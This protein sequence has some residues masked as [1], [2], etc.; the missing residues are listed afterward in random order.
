MD[1]ENFN[2]LTSRSAEEIE[3]E[4]TEKINNLKNP[5]TNE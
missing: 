5:D 3:K 2:A 1:L 4:L